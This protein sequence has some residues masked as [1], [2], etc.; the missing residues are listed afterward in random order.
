MTVRGR[1]YIATYADAPATLRALA[2]RALGK[3]VGR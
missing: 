3:V 2:S 1:D